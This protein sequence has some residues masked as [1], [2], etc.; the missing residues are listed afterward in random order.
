MSD[1]IFSS[2]TAFLQNDCIKDYCQ[3]I[4]FD[5]PEAYVELPFLKETNSGNLVYSL[6][7]DLLMKLGLDRKNIGTPR[8]NPLGEIIK[9]G[10]RVLIKPNLVTGRHYLGRNA[11]FSS[12]VHGSILRP[13]VDYAALA[14]KGEGAIIIADNPIENADFNALMEF[15]GI[16]KMVAELKGR[17]Y[18]NLSVIDLR[19][20]VLKESPDGKF[21]Y[22]SQP[23]DPLGYIAVDLK[24]ASLFGE[25]DDQDNVHYYTL[26]DQSVDHFNPKYSADSVTD[27]YHNPNSHKYIV[28]R[29]VLD[30]EI[31]IN[32]AKMKT[33]C[34]AGVTL[35]LKNMIGMVHLKDCMP[36]HRPGPPPL[37]DS[38]PRYPAAHYIV[39]RKLYRASRQRLRI[40]RFPGFR[41]L[42]NLLQR[43]KIL[44]QQHIEHGNWKGNDTIWRTILDLNRIAVYADKNGIM[45]ESPQRRFFFLVD[46]IISQ[47]GNGPMGGDPVASS[48]VFGGFNP[49]AL[50]ALVVKS[51]GIDPQ[52]IPTVSRLNR[53]SQW[54]LLPK[55]G[56]DIMLPGIVPPRFKFQLP[57]GW[58]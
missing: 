8:W 6:V 51:M 54:G 24:E 40:H 35:S 38:F 46:G 28:S 39:S 45:K 58:R 17:G 31:I 10:N 55:D 21:C 30:A 25:L 26:A 52:L 2:L 9:P 27:K 23:G 50:D 12:I 13:I 42:R 5:P 1:R 3:D 4:P 15:S 22:G 41:I 43:K 16:G 32:I 7:R 37:G 11:L 44:I 33:H 20:R 29:S 49:V 19:P 57:K 18:E 56:F 48:I 47:E 53:V 14:L 36:H 34:K